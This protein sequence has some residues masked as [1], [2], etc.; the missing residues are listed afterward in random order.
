M[1]IHHNQVNDQHSPEANKLVV[2]QVRVTVL[3][4]FLEEYDTHLRIFLCS[5]FQQGFKIQYQGRRHVFVTIYYR[6]SIMKYS[7]RKKYR[8]KIPLVKLHSF[9][10]PFSNLQWSPIGI[11]PKKEIGEFR[12]SYTDGVSI[13]DF[14]T[15]ELCSVSSATYSRWCYQT[16]K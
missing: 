1:P 5:W 8:K 2:T 15:D 4:Q 12:L 7:C 9:N 10:P 6:L 14:I 3:G 13:N 16:N 11:V